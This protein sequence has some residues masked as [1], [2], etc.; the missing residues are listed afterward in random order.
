MKI[1]NAKD[2]EHP[3]VHQFNGAHRLGIH[4]VDVSSN[5]FVAVTSGF[6]GG[7]KLWDLETLQKKAHCGKLICAFPVVHIS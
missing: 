1:W 5:G 4:H 7:L 3:K 2:P 6:E